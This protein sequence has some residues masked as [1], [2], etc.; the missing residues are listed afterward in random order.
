[1]RV[2]V[3]GGTRFIGRAIVERLLRDGHELTLFNRGLARDPFATRVRRILGDRRDPET[4]RNAARRRE[5]DAVVDVIAY[6]EDETATLVDAFRDRV[7]HLIHIST[8]AVYLIRDALLPPFSEDLFDG[9]LKPRTPG[10]ESTWLYAYHKRRC[11]ECLVRAHA[12]SGFPFTSFRLPMVVGLHDYT[13]RADAYL[14]RLATGGP[15]ILPEGGLNT[16]GFLWADDIAETVAS[17]LGNPTSFGRAYNLAQREATSVRKFVELSAQCLGRTAHLLSL[18]SDWLK[19]VGLGTGFS[20]YSHT[21][22]IL[23]DCSL[24]EREL[25]FRPTPPTV[26][27]DRLAHEFSARWDGVMRSFASTRPFELSLAREV[28]RIRLPSYVAPPASP[29][30]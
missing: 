14:E 3:L 11:E 23:L 18:A 24:A 15:L 19:A 10:D 17:N 7:G 9:P 28:A 20:P 26:W 16:W 4:I 1:M 29:A 27:I 25:V 21:E 2:L 6:H 30:S 5:Y 12:E 13:R 8:A 22:D